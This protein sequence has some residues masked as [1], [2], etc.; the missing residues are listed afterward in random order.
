MKILLVHNHYKNR[1]GEDTVFENER[2]M[3]GR[4]G[5]TV[6][7]YERSNDEI[8][9][10][11]GE[12]RSGPGLF[13]TTL[14]SRRS[15]RDILSIIDREKPDV[16]HCHNT[17]PLISPSVYYACARRKTPVVQTLHN[18]RLACLN[19]YLFDDKTCALCEKC[20]GRVPLSGIRR[21]CYRGSLGASA[22]LAAML[23]LHRV[24]GTWRHMVTR[25]IA[26]TESGRDLFVRAGLPAEK[27]VVKPNALPDGGGGRDAEKKL[28]DP[29]S[30]APYFL[31][32]G[33]LSP[34]KG[35]DVL[36]KAWLK[37]REEAGARAPAVSLLVAGDGPM[38]PELERLTGGGRSP[39][40]DG[41]PGAVFLGLLSRDELRPYL[42]GALAV[43][44]PSRWHETF[45]M[46]VVEANAAGTPVIL[47][48]HLG[49]ARGV[50][51][52]R[53]GVTFKNGDI[54]DLARIMAGTAAEPWRTDG[55]VPE[56]CTERG[57]AD[58]LLKIYREAR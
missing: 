21:R 58:R 53:G 51:A 57:N 13:F 50:A 29:R 2:D 16:V 52:R 36:V 22:T 6:L 25:Y 33:R 14:W 39:V 44:F 31:Y 38:R 26:L 27:I 20:L 5:H 3:L 55:A 35:P 28:P 49:I 4:A 10:E 9:G 7:T 11:K 48:D 40:P 37:F 46:S 56:E 1:G 18:Y 47:P 19:G 23:V 15:Y 12:R 30:M 32:A 54:G 24:L 41:R 42:A 8:D 43:V 45:G 34:E 17:F